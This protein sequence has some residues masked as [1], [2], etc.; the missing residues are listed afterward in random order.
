[1]KQFLFLLLLLTCGPAFAQ[2]ASLDQHQPFFEQQSREYQGWL[3][4]TRLSQVFHLRNIQVFRE[5]L[6]VNLQFTSAHPDTV[7]ASW[8][9]AKE[10][11]EADKLL[12]LEEALFLKLLRLMDLQSDQAILQIR[13]DY[14]GLATE[15]F[16]KIYTEDGHLKTD[17]NFS[18]GYFDKIQISLAAGRPAV[19]NRALEAAGGSKEEVYNRVR[20]FVA[21]KYRTNKDCPDSRPEIDAFFSLKDKLLVSVSGLCREVLTQQ[22]ELLFCQVLKRLDQDCSSVKRESLHFEFDFDEASGRLYC[23][24]DG[25]YSNDYLLF[26]G[27]VQDMDDDFESFLQAYGDDFLKALKQWIEQK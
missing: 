3:D 2:P 13:S 14:R 9:A 10:A 25:K 11:Y 19:R 16:L 6:M 12:T 8:Y 18:K 27:K 17:Q 4:E 5:G 26:H 20:Q 24:L 23:Q 7:A 21:Q 15:Y 1:M 22:N